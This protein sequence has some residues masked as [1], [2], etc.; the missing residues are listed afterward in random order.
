MTYYPTFAVVNPAKAPFDLKSYE[1][2][3]EEVERTDRPEAFPFGASWRGC[4]PSTRCSLLTSA[5]GLHSVDAV[6][7]EYLN[8]VLLLHPTIDF[9]YIDSLSF[10]PLTTLEITNLPQHNDMLPF[11]FPNPSSD[12]FPAPTPPKLEGQNARHKAIDERWLPGETTYNGVLRDSEGMFC[13][14]PSCGE[15]DCQIHGQSAACA[16]GRRRSARA[17][18]PLLRRQW[19]TGRAWV[20][21]SPRRT[22]VHRRR[23]LRSFSRSGKR[24]AGPSASPNISIQ[25]SVVALGT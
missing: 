23:S 1:E 4:S 13:P 15:Y 7:Y 18:G 19:P 8:R 24:P 9:K 10:L 17:D 16:R 11:P 3:Y 2:M 25:R 12:R 20:R 5:T 21:T 14:L 22:R 6:C